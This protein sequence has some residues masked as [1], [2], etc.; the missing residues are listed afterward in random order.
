MPHAESKAG[1]R[2]QSIQDSLEI[3][4]VVKIRHDDFEQA[5]LAEWDIVADS[6]RVRNAMQPAASRVGQCKRPA[7]L[8]NRCGTQKFCPRFH[9]IENLAYLL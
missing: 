4:R 5:L 3:E 8:F 7:V 1:K 9:L 2:T 6:G